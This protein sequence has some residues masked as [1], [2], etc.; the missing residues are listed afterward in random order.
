MKKTEKDVKIPFVACDG[1]R[2]NPRAKCKHAHNYESQLK[3]CNVRRVPG[4][5]VR[6]YVS[7]TTNQNKILMYFCTDQPSWPYSGS[8]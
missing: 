5:A 8:L 7:A 4:F 3:T 1:I 2:E 6:I